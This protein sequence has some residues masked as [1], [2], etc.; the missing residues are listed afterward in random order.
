MVPKTH[1]VKRESSLA[2]A[3][4]SCGLDQTELSCKI[5]TQIQFL[6]ECCN[7]IC[8]ISLQRSW[9]SLDLL[10]GYCMSNICNNVILFHEIYRRIETSRELLGY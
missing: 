9:I 6:Y 2:F 7:A 10:F 3:A 1:K 8:N 4:A 5:T